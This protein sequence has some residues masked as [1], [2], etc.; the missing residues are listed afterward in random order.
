M[1]TI[2]CLLLAL[3][4]C[5]PAP[6]SSAPPTPTVRARQATDPPT[7]PHAPPRP[8]P[9]RATDPPT[10]PHPPAAPPPPAPTAPEP[11]AVPPPDA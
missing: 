6:G 7:P 2:G 9:R 10:P 1:R 3:T 8:G 5:S 11:L 4:A